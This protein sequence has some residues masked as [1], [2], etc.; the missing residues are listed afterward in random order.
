MPETQFPRISPVRLYEKGFWVVIRYSITHEKTLSNRSLRC[1]MEVHRASHADSQR[2]WA[3]QDSQPARD[4]K[5]DLLCLKKR[6]PVAY[7]SARLS[8]MAHRLPLLQ[9]MA[10]RR[11]LGEDQSGYSGTS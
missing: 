11:Y 6:L 9:K 8:S 1:R 10:H 3:A 5:R 4:P 7:A 2:A